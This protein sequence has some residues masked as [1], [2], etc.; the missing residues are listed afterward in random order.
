MTEKTALSIVL[1]IASDSLECI[2]PAHLRYLAEQEG[3]SA[4]DYDLK[5]NEAILIVHNKIKEEA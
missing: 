4:N 3:L 5:V 1:A 2:D